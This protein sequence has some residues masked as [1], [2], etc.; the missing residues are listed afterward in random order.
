M[1]AIVVAEIPSNLSE[2][3]FKG[4]REIATIEE[5]GSVHILNK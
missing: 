4:L 5:E 3:D 1:A 2:E